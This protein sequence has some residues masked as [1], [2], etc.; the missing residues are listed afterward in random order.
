MTNKQKCLKQWQ[1]FIDNPGKDKSDWAEANP[2]DAKEVEEF[3]YCHACL[4][5]SLNQNSCIN[6]PIN[7]G[8]ELYNHCCMY[9]S[10]YIKWANDRT[11]ENAELVY[12][13]IKK[14]W[15]E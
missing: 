10:T 5:I 13:T 3:S 9:D 8:T 12:N 4:E 14:T 2:E 6:C 7:W 11:S 1:W 15:K